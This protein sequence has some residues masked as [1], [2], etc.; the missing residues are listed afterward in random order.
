MFE[1][2]FYLELQSFLLHFTDSMVAFVGK[3][4]PDRHFLWGFLAFNLR[5]WLTFRLFLNQPCSLRYLEFVLL[6]QSDE[7]SSGFA[8]FYFFFS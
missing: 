8:L 5:N 6:S 7:N 1:L 4:L 2:L 3:L